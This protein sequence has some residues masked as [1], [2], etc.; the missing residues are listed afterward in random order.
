MNVVQ[1]IDAS[2]GRVRRAGLSLRLR[3]RLRDRGAAR[4][5][6]RSDA[7][8]RRNAPTASMPSSSA[9]RRSP[10]RAPPTSA[11][12]STASG[13]P[14]A[15][16]GRFSKADAGLWRTAPGARG[17]RCRSRR[18]AGTRSRSR[19]EQL[20][21]VEGVRT[22]TTAGDAG[23]QAGMG[24][25]VYL[26]HRARCRTSTSTTP[27]ARCCSCR[28]RAGCGF[29]TEFGIIDVEPGEIAVIPRGVKIRVELQ[30][31][32][33]ARLYLRELR[34]RASPCPSAARSAPTA[35]PTRATS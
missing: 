11:P 17:R 14:C 10:R 26:D 12:G 35:W 18:C 25:H 31:R 19:S 22:I 8:R 34:R 30:G 29:W 6:C 21:F 15:H 33:G 1:Q 7:T 13:R 9:A 3:Q 5:R 28:S 27:T 20:S 24:A 2:A 16:W 23:T 4:A 32:P